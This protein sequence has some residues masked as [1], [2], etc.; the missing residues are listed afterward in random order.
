MLSTNFIIR[1]TAQSVTVFAALSLFSSPASAQSLADAKTCDQAIGGSATAKTA[2]QRMQG[3]RVASPLSHFAAGCVAVMASQ[4]DSAA[5]HFD[6][7]A[8][9][10]PRSSA[11][12]LW[13][14]NISGQLLRL[15]NMQAKARLAPVIRDAYTTAITLDGANLDARE[16]LMQFLLEAPPPL[17]GD[18]AKAAAQAIAIGRIN[19]F[20]G[21]SAQIAVA[22]STSDRPAVEKLLLQATTQFPD[23]VIGWAN[24]SAMQADDHRPADA[25]ATITRWQ[26]RRTNGMFALFSIGRTAAVTGEQM[27]RGVQALQQ[28]LR[29][30]RG[31]NDPPL[32]NAHYRLAQIYEKQHKV[33]DAKT[34]Y[35]VAVRLNPSLRDAQL[36][37]ERLR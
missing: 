8:K 30:Q 2:I 32:A 21:V 37:L 35:Q 23:S 26:A 7:A 18:K 33:A 19:P 29:G 12:F 10:N 36:A 25:F 13:V 27:D 28:Y 17:G 15:G 20:R 14:G 5:A 22:S 4:W 6:A 16:G 31:P 1:R 3:A 34:E 9:G 24:L 11:A